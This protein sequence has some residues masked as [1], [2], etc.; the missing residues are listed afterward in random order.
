[1]LPSTALESIS[2]VR[3]F[4]WSGCYK[5]RVTGERIKRGGGG[6][7]FRRGAAGGRADDVDL[8]QQAAG[9]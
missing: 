8:S 3:K 1:M 9:R 2:I 4:A 5:T 7:G 6:I